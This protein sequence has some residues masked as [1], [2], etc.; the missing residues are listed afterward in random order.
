MRPISS[1]APAIKLFAA[2][3]ERGLV[4]MLWSLMD[5]AENGCVYQRLTRQVIK[6]RRLEIARDW[7]LKSIYRGVR[8]VVLVGCRR[9][10]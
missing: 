8:L 3:T 4:V 9:G 7:S 10:D 5:D 6:D 2:E 1:R